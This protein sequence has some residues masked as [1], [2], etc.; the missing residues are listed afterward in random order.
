MCVLFSAVVDYSRCSAEFDESVDEDFCLLRD[1]DYAKL[2]A[3]V[4]CDCADVT[5]FAP[6][7]S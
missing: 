1:R 2:T 5:V 7:T 3:N 4:R 6:G